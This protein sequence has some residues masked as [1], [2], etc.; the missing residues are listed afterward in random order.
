MLHSVLVFDALCAHVRFD[1]L[2]S[3]SLVQALGEVCGFE[4]GECTLCWAG[5]FPSWPATSEATWK[6]VDS[7][8]G[9]VRQGVYTVQARRVEASLGSWRC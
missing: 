1:G 6:V 4:E 7:V 9:V 8:K 5:A 2:S 3:L